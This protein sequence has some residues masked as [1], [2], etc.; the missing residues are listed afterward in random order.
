MKNLE[1]FNLYYL[2]NLPILSPSNYKNLQLVAQGY[3]Y[4]EIADIRF[5][6][7]QTVKNQI[8]LLKQTIGAKNTHHLLAL[9]Y[10]VGIL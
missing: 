2:E 5:V 7:H 10:Q 1:E 6:S 9:A 3:K 8:Y 4:N